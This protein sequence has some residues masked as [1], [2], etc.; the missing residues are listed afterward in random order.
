MKSVNGSKIYVC[1]S[2]I[3]FKKPEQN[4]EIIFKKN[5]KSVIGLYLGTNIFITAQAIR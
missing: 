4:F 1:F 2:K 5:Y 3:K